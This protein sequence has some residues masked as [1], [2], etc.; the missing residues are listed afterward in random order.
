MPKPE[1]ELMAKSF[2]HARAAVAPGRPKR[3][4]PVRIY[5]EE[6]VNPASGKALTAE[7]HLMLARFLRLRPPGPPN[8]PHSRGDQL[9]VY[10]IVGFDTSKR[11]RVTGNYLA[12][13]R[14]PIELVA[15]PN[16][17]TLFAMK[18]DP[19]L[20][21]GTRFMHS[22][23]IS[24]IAGAVIDPPQIV[25]FSASPNPVRLEGESTSHGRSM[26]S[27]SLV[28]PLSSW[29]ITRMRPTQTSRNWRTSR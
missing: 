11:R 12:L 29:R 4:E 6:A 28:T 15:D 25:D 21:Y 17:G 7:E 24:W 20:V 22:V 1:V 27:Q 5:M 19:E 9:R 16:G 23:N 2:E 3:F 18:F 14:A 26:I 8:A 13:W 10:S